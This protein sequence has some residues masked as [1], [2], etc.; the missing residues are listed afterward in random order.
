VTLARAIQYLAD[1]PRLRREMSER[2]RARAEATLE[3]SKVTS[4]YLSIYQGMQKHAPAR[5]MV[6]AATASTP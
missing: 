6:P 5:R 1:D 3:W 2:N 4:R